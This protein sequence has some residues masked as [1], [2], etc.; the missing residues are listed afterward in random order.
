MKLCLHAKYKE[1][2]ACE[3]LMGE[4]SLALTLQFQKCLLAN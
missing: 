2:K 1:M 4:Q 3:A